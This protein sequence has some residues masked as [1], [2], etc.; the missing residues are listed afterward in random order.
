MH[1]VCNGTYIKGFG[2]FDMRGT[3]AMI[4]AY[5]SF[6]RVG[7]SL[8]FY[9]PYVD[10]FCRCYFTHQSAFHGANKNELLL[11]SS[12]ES[13]KQVQELLNDCSG[14]EM[15]RLKIQLQQS[16]ASK[17]VTEQLCETLQV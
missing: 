17:S 1:V 9:L 14:A 8:P 12:Q 11:F 10:L 5:T 4:A 3:W 15:S 2:L 6:M 16:I 7:W 13:Q